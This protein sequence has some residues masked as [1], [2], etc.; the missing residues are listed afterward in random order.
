MTAL[1]SPHVPETNAA[2]RRDQPGAA[3]EVRSDASSP[4]DPARS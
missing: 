4:L 1:N 3:Q 2:H